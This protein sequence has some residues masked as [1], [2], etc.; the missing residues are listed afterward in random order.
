MLANEEVV[1]GVCERCGS[2]VVRKEKSQWM[3]AITKYAQ[4][5]IDDLDELDYIER[6]K[7]QQKNWIGRSTGAELSFK[8]NMGDD[9]T[10]YTT[11]PDTLFGV[12][13]MV[14]SPEHP[15]L[16]KWQDK[17]ENRDEV[18]AYQNAAA[19][20]SDFERGE[21]NK[22]KTGDRLQGVEVI[23]PATGSVLPMFVSDYVLMGYG[24]GIVMGVPGHDQRDWEFATKF[25]L[26]IIEVDSGG[27]I[28]KEAFVAKD[29]SAIMVNSG[30]M[31]GMTV[32]EAIPAMKQYVLE[33]GW[34]KEKVNYKLR[35]W[36][37]SRQRYWGEPIP[38]VNCPKCGWVAIPE[39]ELPLVLP[40]V[41]SYE[42]TDDGERQVLTPGV[43]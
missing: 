34:G 41:D 15:L 30:F 8:T 13:Y 14:I 42:V 4:R 12:T 40:Q 26:P 35:D 23:N 31:N 43:N 3:L 39:S 9:V 36:V 33:Q 7:I 32:K 2:E 20:K 1:D 5:L 25:G 10:V 6:V 19:H 29:D 24:T 11:R 38:L 27:D 16:K 22:E 28:T 21:L 17:I 18:A 37:F